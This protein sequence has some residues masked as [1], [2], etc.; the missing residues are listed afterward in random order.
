MQ[1]WSLL[2]LVQAKHILLFFSEFLK[3][4]SAFSDWSHMQTFKISWI[5]ISLQ[6]WIAETPEAKGK[7]K[8]CT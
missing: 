8:K 7:F 1:L 5:K 6:V 2:L 4:F 3:M